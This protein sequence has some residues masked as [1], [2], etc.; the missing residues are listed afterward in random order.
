M[1]EFKPEDELKP[2]PS[3]RRP[4]RSR[5]SAEFDNEPQINIDDVDLDA[6]DRRPA[7]A[8]RE[9][10]QET[11]EADESLAD[12]EEVQER[13]PRKRK[14]APPKGP[15]SRQ[16]LMMALGIFVLV[17]LIIGIGSALK[18][19]DTTKTDDAQAQNAEKNIDLSGNAGSAS[20]QANGAQPQPGNTSAANQN[21]ANAPQDI[22]LPPVSSTPTQ[23]ESPSAPQGQQR[24]EVPGDLNNALT[25]QQGQIDNAVAGSTLPTEPATV[26][27]V[28]G[29]AAAAQ[30]SR[31][32]AQSEKPAR[33]NAATTTRPERKQMVIESEPR[34]TQT[35]QSKPQQ[36][37]AKPATTEQKPA[38]TPKR[39][40]PATGTA[41]APVKAPATTATQAPKSTPAAS[42]PSAPAGGASAGNVGAL[43]SAPGSHY[44]LQLS[45][46]SNYN[47]LNAWA[48]K[49]NLKNYVVYQT[50]RNGQP[51]YVLVSGVYGSKDEAKRAVS[52]LPADVQAKNPWAKPIHQVQADLK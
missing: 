26:A 41:S 5:K 43:K 27:P 42:Q 6:D 7:R 52:S 29:N 50:T 34:K 31:D 24:V 17:L 2:D 8:R 9:Q 19:P 38:S 4:G 44:T 10:T 30:P 32:T 51:W 47:N 1:D 46:S 18:G 49:E 37:P 23:A 33:H 40:E 21:S 25:Q 15:I 35:T 11:Y 22:S 16:H 36:T 39:S 13:R 14:K 28:N 48:K 3:D 20:D 45:S 12:D